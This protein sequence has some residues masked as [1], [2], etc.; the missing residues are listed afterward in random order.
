MRQRA[1]LTRRWRAVHVLGLVAF[2]LMSVGINAVMRT[3][4]AATHYR[5]PHEVRV[6]SS[7]LGEIKLEDQGLSTLPPQDLEAIAVALASRYRH[8]L[9]DPRLLTQEYGFLGRAMQTQIERV[10]RRQP[11]E[12]EGRQA[13]EHPLVQSIV[14]A[15]TYA[16]S[17]MGTL[18]FA[19]KAA[20]LMLGDAL[21]FVALFS[22]V[23]GLV[24][25]G[26]LLRAMGL[27]LVRNDGRPASRVRV[28]I[29]T[30]IAWAPII[31]LR[32]A[33]PGASRIEFVASA[34]AVLALLAGATAAIVRPE[35]GLQDRLAGT[36][37]VPR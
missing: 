11:T 17:G 29:R 18:G 7:L 23:T 30:S 5:L 26:G 3:S 2:P 28:L 37:I 32:I 13:R 22:L 16:T 27:E 15:P 12:A 4:L 1:V 6:V 31:A 21:T 20:I 34:L 24:F 8:L 36:W 9:T 35:R 10:L 14:N 19:G 33:S 25:R